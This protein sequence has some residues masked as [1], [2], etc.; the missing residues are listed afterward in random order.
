MVL[1][2]H[3]PNPFAL[4]EIGLE[5]TICQRPFTPPGSVG[6]TGGK[7]AKTGGRVEWR[8]QKVPNADCGLRNRGGSGW[9]RISAV[10]QLAGEPPSENDGERRWREVHGLPRWTA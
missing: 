6:N 1:T 10:G 5:K 7:V 4:V 2:C 9:G 3:G 8:M